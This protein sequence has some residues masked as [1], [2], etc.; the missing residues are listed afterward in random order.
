LIT[1]STMIRRCYILLISASV[2][3]L[4][5]SCNSGGNLTTVVGTVNLDG[6]PVESG[7]IHF[8]S[9]ASSKASG[10]ASV[11]DGKF[12]VASK[13]GFPPGEYAVELQ[14]YRITGRTI[15]DPDKGARPELVPVAP[16]D[17]PQMI[18]LTR[19]NAQSLTLN[20]SSAK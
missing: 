14:A 1:L 9:S 11:A 3:A 7:I 19:D 20:Y 10:G 17:S 16:S 6:Q 18:T 8:Q 2:L 13:D 15:Y 4:L 12:Q 5:S